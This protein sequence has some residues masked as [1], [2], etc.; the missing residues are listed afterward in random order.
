MLHWADEQG[1]EIYGQEK[2][3]F[4]K[5]SLL[6]TSS[7]LCLGLTALRNWFYFI[8]F[9]FLLAVL[10]GQ[11]LRGQETKSQKFM[12][13]TLDQRFSTNMPQLFLKHA[14]LTI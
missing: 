6:L 14:I 13:N 9:S 12:K 7:L 8:L 11:S 2:E 4:S 1:D 3:I 5:L 10:F